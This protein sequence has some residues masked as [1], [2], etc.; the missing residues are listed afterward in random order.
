[1][2]LRYVISLHQRQVLQGLSPLY[3]LALGACNGG[4][5]SPQNEIASFSFVGHVIKGPLKNSLVGLDYNGDGIVDSSTV[6]SASDGSYI[7]TA[8]DNAYTV[9]AVA[10]DT[11][12][13]TSS[14]T[15]LSGVTL[16]APNGASVV[17]PTTTLMEESKLTS[18]QVAN[19]LGLPEGVDPLNFNPYASDADPTA[20][21]A[22][23]KA[24]H[25][26]MSVVTAFASSVEGAGAA[27]EEA[28]KAA[29]ASVVAVVKAKA[30]NLTYEATTNADKSLNLT[31]SADLGLIKTQVQT[32]VSTV[33][34]V[35]TTAFNTLI[36]ETTVAIENVNK[37]FW[38]PLIS[39][40][41]LQ[42]TSSQ[43]QKCCQIK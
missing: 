18:A 16:K 9:V 41:I 1:M 35:N 19:V 10:D 38:L 3:L 8:S 39:P 15:V 31:T 5:C 13:D 40:R 36:D 4:G 30:A 6:R 11:T 42:K 27:E 37:R 28:F 26:I 29:L 12:V 21:L 2:S 23:E 22:V 17:T 34:G 20:A 33:A 24:S 32:E 7:L 14:G 25:Q 43:R